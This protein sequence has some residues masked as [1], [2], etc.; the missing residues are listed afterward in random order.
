MRANRKLVCTLSVFLQCVAVCCSVL[1]CVAVCCSVLPCAVTW[2]WKE[3]AREQKAGVHDQ[4]AA[5][6]TGGVER[7]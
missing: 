1:Q 3:D 2:L 4:C 6:S 7:A 5:L